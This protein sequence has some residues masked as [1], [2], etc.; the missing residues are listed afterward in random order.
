MELFPSNHSGI[1]VE[2][3]INTPS[4]AFYNATTSYI[5]FCRETL[6]VQ[7]TYELWS[8]IGVC[9][10]LVAFPIVTTLYSYMTSPIRNIPGPRLAALTRWYEFYYNAIKSFQY[11]QKV[12]ELHE[13]YGP[14]VRINPNEVHIHD[15][16]FHSTFATKFKD[17]IR[18]DPWYYNMGAPG[19]VFLTTD[20]TVHKA[21]REELKPHMNGQLAQAT[22]KLLQRKS[23]ELCAILR[24]YSISSQPINLSDAYR[25][26]GHD[27]IAP[28]LLGED[29]EQLL[30]Q[31]D[32]G[33]NLL[34]NRELF[35]LASISRMFPTVAK[36]VP[37][38][39]SSSM[40]EK[41]VPVLRFGTLIAEKV[42]GFAKSSQER[43]DKEYIAE[44]LVKDEKNF[45]KRAT[46]DNTVSLILAGGEA[47]AHSLVH[48]SFHLMQNMEM[49]DSLREDLSS[50]EF[51]NNMT[52]NELLAGFPYLKAVAK[53]GLRTEHQNVFRFPRISSVP[54]QY[55]GYTI[56]AGTV[57]TTSRTSI[58]QN[59]EAF[60]DPGSFKPERW[61][62]PDISK[63]NKNF[64]PFGKGP[65][66]CMGI[67]LSQSSTYYTLA[68]I[69]SEF[70]LRAVVDLEALKRDG[71]LEV[72][73]NSRAKGLWVTVKKI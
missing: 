28:A 1:S 38:L 54:I 57:I 65:M 16:E 32:L 4:V 69:F 43:M 67:R 62:A 5:S 71:T 7:P 45:N 39:I 68:R 41:Y 19:A 73:P 35:R 50:G 31:K 48:A 22:P 72:Y 53:E 49:Q 34:P 63:L 47:I 42:T 59:P 25:S 27:L 58:H 60:P 26:L 61:L 30:S 11:A 21:R 9:L 36:V 20:P 12:A 6:G 40:Q 55:G 33:H 70:E 56:P 3:A 66:A 17:V 29:Y 2:V 14:I 51:R 10:F 24:S 52:Y 46:V 18:K 64:A 8:T 15:P 13:Q 37:Y 23:D 44:V